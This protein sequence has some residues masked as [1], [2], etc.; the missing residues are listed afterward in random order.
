MRERLLPPMMLIC[1]LAC[2]GRMPAPESAPLPVP[3]AP[4][5]LRPPGEFPLSFQWRQR[6]TATWPEG[7]QSFDAALQN[8]DGE[9]TLIGL[10]PMGL[11][12]FVITLKPDASVTFDNRTRRELPFEPEFIL[13]DVQRVYFPWLP[14]VEAGFEGQREGVAH[15][16]RIVEH[17]A[18]GQLSARDFFALDAEPDAAA[19]PE[20]T[21]RY[22]GWQAGHDA[23]ERAELHHTKLG[24][25]LLIE[26]LQQARL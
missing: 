19:E 3:S 22:T 2:G 24:Y 10:S 23:A 26:T 11:P 18:G 4:A 16:R 20:V 17:Y 7:S 8:R 12:G 14:A 13:A 9:L 1:L 25:S 21:V 5:A 15:G 6:V